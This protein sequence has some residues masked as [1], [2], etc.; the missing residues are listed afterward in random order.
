[1]TPSG[2]PA[3]PQTEDGTTDWEIVFEDPETGFIQLVAQSPSADIL[4]QTTTVVIEK[5]F[6]RRGDEEEVVSLKAQLE[7]ILTSGKDLDAQQTGVSFLLR[8]I[9]DTRIEKARIYVERKRSGAA[10]DRR[11]GW[12]WKIDALLKPKVLIPVSI[13]FV[14]LI[15]GLVFGVLQTTL[16]PSRPDILAQD[17][18]LTGAQQEESEDAEMDGDGKTPDDAE[19]EEAEPEAPP[20]PPERIEIWLKTMRWPLS[21]LSTKDRPQYFAVILFVKDWDTKIGVCRHTVNIMD[22]LYQAFNHVLPQDRR[23]TD[24]ELSDLAAVIP[25]A[26]DQIFG[27]SVILEAQVH[28]YGS[29]GFKAATLPPY[30]KSPDKD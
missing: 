29:P 9:K 20:P 7:A 22:K 4:R 23:A 28:R 10:I 18:A 19:V 17:D 2:K 5:L 6:T 27:S 26:V 12:L 11:T 21:Q 15:T 13:L 24:G 1:M 3:W 30:C 8:Q 14:M 25:S 16:G